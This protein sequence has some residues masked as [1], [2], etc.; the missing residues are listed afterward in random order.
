MINAI[1]R[2][3]PLSAFEDMTIGMIFDY[4]Y[5]YDRLCNSTEEHSNIREATQDDFDKF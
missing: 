2:E 4:I 5:E 3:L 1:K